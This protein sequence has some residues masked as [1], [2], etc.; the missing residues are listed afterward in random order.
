MDY[1]RIPGLIW[2][3]A[4]DFSPIELSSSRE[5]MDSRKFLSL[6]KGSARAEQQM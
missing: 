3:S 5:G 6:A 2:T 1:C 4:L